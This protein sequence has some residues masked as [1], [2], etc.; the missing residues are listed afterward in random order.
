MRKC[1]GLTIVVIGVRAISIPEE[2]A[3]ALGGVGGCVHGC[4]WEICCCW[5]QGVGHV[6]RALLVI[7][8]G[9]SA[10]GVRCIHWRII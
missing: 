4:A 3:T 7:Y 1:I 8:V 2:I 5:C 6:V 9:I 10:A